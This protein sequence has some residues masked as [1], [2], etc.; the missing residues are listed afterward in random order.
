MEAYVYEENNRGFVDYA[1]VIIYDMSDKLVMALQTDEY[2]KISCSLDGNAKYQVKVS[3]RDYDDFT[4]VFDLP[5]SSVKPVYFKW[6]LLRSPGYIFD[7]TL[8]EERR[9][10]DVPTDAIKGALIEI[11]NRT[12]N[13][14]ELVLRDY[15]SPNF[16]YTLKNGNHYTILIRKEGFIAKRIEAYVNVDDCVLCLDG[17]GSVT[18]GVTE[19]ISSNGR[20]GV[21]LAN[22]ELRRAAIGKSFAIKNINYD[23]DKWHIRPDAAKILNGVIPIF[24]K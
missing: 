22:I 2:G 15:P 23:Y 17:V 11:Y 18:P 16:Q 14:E 21:V 8:A 19:N 5:A 24:K 9:D 13:K 6:E 7:C 10:A 4:T 1:D 3:K 12:K 20:V